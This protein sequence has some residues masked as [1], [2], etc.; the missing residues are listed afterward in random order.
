[1]ANLIGDDGDNNL[2]GDSENDSIFGGGGSDTLNGGDGV[3]TIDGGAGLDD[4]L[5]FA[6]A[7]GGVTVTLVGT[8]PP[9]QTASVVTFEEAN[10]PVLSGFGGAEDATIV[11]DPAGGGNM[12]ARVVKSGTAEL[13][14]GTTVGFGGNTSIPAIPFAPGST[15][16]TLRVWVPEAGITVRLKVEDAANGARSCEVDAVT[17]VANG[18]E[19]LTF[20]FSDPV[21]GTAALNFDFTYDKASVF[22]D[23]GV[24]GAAGGAGTYYFDDLE[25]ISTPPATG[26]IRDDGYGNRETVTGVENILGSAHDDRL[27]GDEG[28]NVLSGADGNDTLGGGEGDDEL[29]GGN[30]DDRLDGGAG[31][32]VLAGGAGS[33]TL[34]GGADVDSFEGGDG[35]D[36]VSF[37]GATNGVRVSLLP[38]D[39]SISFVTFDEADA[40]VL[41]GFGGADDSSI[42]TDPGGGS[43]LVGKVVKSDTAEL[44]AGTTVGFGSGASI[45][46]IP[47]EPGNTTLTLR[48]W[49]PEAGIKV[50]LKVEDS[51]DGT[52]SCEVD[53]L[54]TVANG[55]ETLTFDFSEQA[56][57]TAALN[58]DFT[59]DKA[60]VF[61][62]FG[63]SGADG[64]GGTYYFDDLQ[65]PGPVAGTIDDD[66]FGNAELIRDV[67]NV[68]GSSL[69][70]RI[71]GDDLANRL[72][73]NAGNDSLTGG[74]GHDTLDG[75]AGAD[76]LIGGA[77]NDSLVG[78]AGNDRYVV[79]SRNDRI[80]ETSTARTEVDTVVSSVSWSLGE[81]LER[82]TLTGS[83]DTNGTGNALGNLII[84][85]SGD[86]RLTGGAGNDTLTGGQGA[87]IFRF[88]SE[89]DGRT[90]VD[91]IKDFNPVV[92]VIELEN[93]IFA[94]LTK[95][96]ALSAANFRANAGGKA[97]DA[98]DF[99]VYETDTGK[100][101]YDADGSGEGAAVLIATLTDAPMLTASDIFVT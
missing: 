11:E 18:W 68:I 31:A 36:T 66:G 37:A 4:L 84:G 51:A 8:T 99:I 41:R 27:T 1:M 96:G 39:A 64:G 100:L 87:D 33:D 45:S 83:A 93:G 88:A 61:F 60:S 54:T 47:F 71:E 57:G 9:P 43:A 19:T 16:M 58:F 76:T 32:D 23:F 25:F 5:S 94:K 24:P 89:L 82:L 72:T 20:D 55:W 63:V 92:D 78:G 30:G 15:T 85:N 73:G 56:Q 22:F 28:A 52:R 49:V 81:N 35:I 26:T 34:N 13:W 97:I 44:W 98:N 62:N 40:P 12:V 2:V 17:T 90:N 50:R 59:Y 74:A 7:A 70:D 80:S 10:A 3:D 67:E 95:L 48:V 6:G 29:D 46:A 65:F 86:N 21:S 14:A 38:V 101:F 79:N 77:G 91:T 75:G 53:V 69:A 42:A